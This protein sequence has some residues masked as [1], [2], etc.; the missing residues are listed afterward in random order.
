MQP[1][2]FQS[3]AIDA[4]DRGHSVLVAAPTGAGKTLVADYAV[5]RA[6]AAGGKAIYTSP[7]KALSNQKHRDLARSL[8][9]D[10]VGLLTGDRTVNPTAPVVVMTTEVLRALLYDDASLLDGLHSIVLDEFHY[11]QHHER[12]PVWEEVV[13][14]APAGVALVCLSATVPDVD[15]LCGWLSAVHGPTE[16]VVEEC[17]PVGLSYLYA[18][19]SLQKVPPLLLPMFVDGKLNP[20]AELHDGV[21]RRG[22][23]TRGEGLRV[24][25]RARTTTPPR[26]DLLAVLEAQRLLPAIWFVLSRAGCDRA[27]AQL[28]DDGVRL[29]DDDE[30]AAAR[31]L[32]DSAASLMSDGERAAADFGAFRAA[33]E[34]GL[35]VHHG[36]QPPLLREVVELAYGE[37]IVKVAFATETLALGVNLP[38]RSVVVDRVTRP[39]GHGRTTVS[40]AEFAQLAGRAG[41]RGVDSIGHVI[42]PWDQHV[43]LHRVAALAAGRIDSLRS[44]FAASPAMVANLARRHGRNEARACFRRSLAQFLADADAELLDAQIAAAKDELAAAASRSSSST[45]SSSSASTS[46]S[47]R[48]PVTLDHL[49]VGDV[50]MDPGWPAFGRAVVVGTTR[51][52]RGEIGLH[53][54]RPDARRMVLTAKDFRAAPVVVGHLDLPAWTPQERGHARRAAALLA[55]MPPTAPP[56]PSTPPARRPRK[57]DERRDVDL[58]RAA[59]SIAELKARRDALRLGHDAELHAVIALLRERGHLDEDRWALTD[60][61]RMVR[62]LFHESGLLVAESLAAGVFDA[63]DVPS[64]A[65]LAAIFIGAPR[66]DAAP[67]RLP[68]RI[69]QERWRHVLALHRDLAR[70]QAAHDLPAVAMPDS[71]MSTPIHRWVA[72][73][74]LDASLDGMG[75]VAGDFVRAARQTGEL[76][77]QIA[78]VAGPAVAP[79]A[80]A[81]I[82]GLARGIV[83]ASAA[84][85]FLRV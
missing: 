5:H 12:G 50:V 11:V 55:Q 32:A 74:D 76:L 22:G 33:L 35:A 16:V 27:V 17:R 82:D 8:G 57:D 10:R 29:T 54:V 52:R 31:E 3:R 69:L 60:S 85:A 1:D 71:T 73:D 68:T 34:H 9:A 18:V 51:V 6:L 58:A 83:V 37:G 66:Q 20:V 13:I 7:L 81:A 46:S 4:L 84:D 39:D 15:A 38:A 49:Q 25:D 77:E 56:L 36:G 47:A 62:R 67:A 26:N 28:L 79:A 53:A 64:T 80:E 75:V 42:V 48:P 61:G 44:Y 23:D 19:G 30:A 65:A 59:A 45:E 70:A 24:R 14:H 63:L 78:A 41:R 21:R 72:G 43:P 2:P 40:A